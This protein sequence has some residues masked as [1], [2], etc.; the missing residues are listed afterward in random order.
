MVL[1]PYLSTCT[2]S[3]GSMLIYRASLRAPNA[4]L[5]EAQHRAEGRRSVPKALK[6]SSFSRVARSAESPSASLRAGQTATHA[7]RI[8]PRIR[9]RTGRN[10]DIL[11]HLRRRVTSYVGRLEVENLRFSLFTVPRFGRKICDFTLFTVAVVNLENLRFPIYAV[12]NFKVKSAILPYIA[13]IGGKSE[14]FPI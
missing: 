10:Q 1:V 8:I 12:V 2:V 4:P 9:H 5:G 6:D 13:Y 7:R 14:I 11:I 3:Y